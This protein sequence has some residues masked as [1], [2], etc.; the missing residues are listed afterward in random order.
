MAAALSRSSLFRSSHGSLRSLPSRGQLRK[1]TP[2][3]MT[4]GVRSVL[5]RT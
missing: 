2:L 3:Y 4:K 5:L 1:L